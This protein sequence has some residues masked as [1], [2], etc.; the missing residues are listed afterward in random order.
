MSEAVMQSPNAQQHLVPGR[1]VVM[2]SE[3][4]IDNLLG[5]VLKGLSNRQYVVLVIKSEIPP[6]EKNMVSIGKKSSDP[7]QGFFIAPK[8]KRGFED[9]YYSTTSSRKG[10]GVIKIEL[11][12]HGAAAGVGY[13]VR[14]FD[15]KEFLC[16]CVSKIKIDLVRLLED[17]NKAAFSQTVQQLLDLKS[18]GNKFPPALDPVKDLKLKD[19][20]LVETYYKWTSLLQKKCNLKPQDPKMNHSLPF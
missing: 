11:P 9:D 6:P 17:G 13:E 5:V 8:S 2:K 15:N 16:I 19:A 18:D 10:T 14:A 1:V 12:Y 7:S 4:G 20:E 3:T